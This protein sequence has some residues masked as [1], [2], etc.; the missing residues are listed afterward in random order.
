MSTN[1]TVRII[2]EHHGA[3]EE[4]SNQAQ[5][6]TEDEL[7]AISRFLSGVT[8]EELQAD[9]AKPVHKLYESI[10]RT[11]RKIKQGQ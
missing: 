4:A 1:K 9:Q 11:C 5:E 10:L 7:R 3:N 2:I 8:M 6:Y